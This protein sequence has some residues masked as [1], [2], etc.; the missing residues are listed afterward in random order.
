MGATHEDGRWSRRSPSHWCG[1]YAV[2]QVAVGA[3]G[4]WDEP[5]TSQPLEE[6][7]EG[8]A[9]SVDFYGYNWS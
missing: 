4:E 9:P 5:G 8:A 7:A 2:E 6:P 1:E 3:A